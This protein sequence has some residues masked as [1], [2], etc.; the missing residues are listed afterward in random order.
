MNFPKAIATSLTL[1]LVLS[2]VFVWLEPELIR[3]VEDQFKITQ[4]VTAE[5][6]F[7]TAANDITM[8]GSIPGIT[9][10]TASGTTT[11]VVTTNNNTGYT[12]T[13]TASSSPAMQGETQGGTISDYTPA[14]AGV[15][16]FTFSVPTGSEFGFSVS[17]ST[18]ADL[19]QKFLDNGT[20][21]NTGALDTSVNSC[22]MGLSTT[23][24]STIV[25]TGETSASGSTSSLYF[26]TRVNAGALAEDNYTATTTLTAV[27]N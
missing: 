2:F 3:A 25:T 18:T 10:G 6:A 1:T 17:A 12:M 11:V 13:I 5:I 7:T 23:A 14:T 21:C 19:A 22:W 20:T 4:V 9:G 8:S 26:I 16:D 27:T 15:P 24:T